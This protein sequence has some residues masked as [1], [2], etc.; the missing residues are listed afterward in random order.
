MDLG[1]GFGYFRWF[2]AGGSILAKQGFD[3]GCTQ[4]IGARFRGDP[5]KYMSQHR[6]LSSDTYGYSYGFLNM[7]VL[8]YTPMP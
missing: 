7:T 2:V 5:P 8:Q 4:S 3:F 1:R 6:R